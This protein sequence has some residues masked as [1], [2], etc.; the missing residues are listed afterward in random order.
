M[1][2]LDSTAAATG[3]GVF[4]YFD[5]ANGDDEVDSGCTGVPRALR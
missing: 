2:D 4:G 3:G 1:K 5:A